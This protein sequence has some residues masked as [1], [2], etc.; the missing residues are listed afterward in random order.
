LL[1]LP[2]A[3][4]PED[5]GRAAFTFIVHDS[6]DADPAN[7][8]LQYALEILPT[9]YLQ[10]R[11]WDEDY[12]EGHGT[13]TPQDW[14]GSVPPIAF[15]L[16]DSNHTLVTAMTG[17]YSLHIEPE[18][19]YAF[20]DENVEIFA[21]Q[22]RPIFRDLTPPPFLLV[23]ADIDS[24]RLRY[25]T[26]ALTE[27]GVDYRIW[28]KS[29]GEI[30]FTDVFKT[31]LYYSG[32]SVD[33]ILSNDDKVHL[34]GMLERGRSII[35]TGQNIAESLG[36][37]PFLQQTLHARLATT[38]CRRS[39][40]SGV[41]GDVIMRDL[42]LLLLGNGGAANQFSP[43]GIFPVEGATACALYSDRGDTAA[44]VRWEAPNNAKML[45][46]SFGYEAISGQGNTNT[47]RQLLSRMLTWLELGV[48]LP[49]E[50]PLPYSP[51]LITSYPNPF[52]STVTIVLAGGSYKDGSIDIY[53]VSGRMVRSIGSS[54]GRFVWDGRNEQGENLATGLY[55]IRS[56]GSPDGR[57]NA[58]IGKVIYLR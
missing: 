3:W 51:M 1:Q 28:N 56:G 5:S 8:T 40:I 21:G 7:D 47:R 18:F 41:A 43:D 50:E 58:P 46:L 34:A 6:L 13:L 26:E 30:P 27:R 24:S 38:Y 55:L 2:E 57:L 20:I 11:L 4:T 45:F 19:P 22:P 15:E 49:D 14:N 32:N 17:N 31:V 52:N 35:L 33:S 16:S 36:D 48:D 37:D 25:Y 23:N 10:V 54:D 12:I 53:D 39:Q 42:N 29:E 9:G 44:G